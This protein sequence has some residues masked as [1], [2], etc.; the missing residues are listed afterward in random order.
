M[1]S[2]PCQPLF[3]QAQSPQRMN[4]KIESKAFDHL[5]EY[6]SQH[7]PDAT[8]RDVRNK[9]RG[10]TEAI[11]DAVLGYE[12]R[13]IHI[14]IKGSTQKTLPTNLRFAHQTI[15]SALGKY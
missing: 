12:K 10:Q 7:F 6:V 9:G 3:C 1:G 8:L 2:K 15:S 14:E 4:K 11:G 13:V 5:K